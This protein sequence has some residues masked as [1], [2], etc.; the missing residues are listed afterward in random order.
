MPAPRGQALGRALHALLGHEHRPRGEPLAAAAVL[1]E[2]HDLGRCLHLRQHARELLGTVRVPVDQPRQVLAR[3]RRMLVGQRGQRQDRVGR[4]PLAVAL[5]DG[6]MFRR[7]L[8]RL[9]PLLPACTGRSDLVLRLK[10]KALL[11][12]GAMVDADLVPQ[13]RQA[14]VGAGRPRLTPPLQFSNAVPLA[15]LPA[16]PLRPGL[17]HRQHHVRMRLGLAVR[18]HRPM[19]VQIGHHPARNELL[20]D[21]VARERHPLLSAQLPRQ[22][23]LHLTG[24][25]CVLALLRRLKNP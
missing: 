6:P 13:L 11:F 21:E 23:E 4:N 17:A 9:A 18:V 5:R 1:A 20:R 19:H 22:R 15:H 24:Q 14:L 2:P 12:E 10:I 7:A 16:K 3:E 8:G 25:L